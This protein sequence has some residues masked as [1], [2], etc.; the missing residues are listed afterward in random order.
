MSWRYLRSKRKDIFISLISVISISGVAVG[1][2]ALII[3][4]AVMTGMID[5]LRDKILGTYS[6]IMVFQRGGWMSNYHDLLERLGRDDDVVG[7]APFIYWP[8]MIQSDTLS[9][10]A[11]MKAIDVSA[12]RTASDLEAHIQTGTLNL[13]DASERTGFGMLIGSVLAEKLQV[14]VG[15]RVALVSMLPNADSKWPAPKREV[16]EITGIFEFGMHEYDGNLSYIAVDTAQTFLERPDQVTGLEIKVKNMFQAKAVAE[17]MQRELGIGFKLIDW[18]EANKNLF[19]LYGLY[20]KLMFVM[21]TIIVVVACLNVA[22][23]LIMM[24]MEKGHDIAI[25]KSMGASAGSI[26]KLFVLQGTFIGIA[27]TSL[28]CLVGIVVCW[29]ADTYHIIQLDGAVYLLNH[30]PFKVMP[31]DVVL[32]AASS[33]LICFLST[34]YPARQA[35]RLDPAVALRCE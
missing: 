14:T 33:L 32:V 15:D 19:S 27:G 20:K 16:F 2:M 24:V 6:H 3:V 29:I 23:T 28:G 11:T 21:L 25:L 9:T 26:Q 35:A 30:L 34:L 22:S 4:L 5:G 13:I 31:L 12:E 18:S 8:V 17:S 1:V 7:I 10:E